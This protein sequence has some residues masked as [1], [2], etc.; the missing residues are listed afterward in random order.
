VGTGAGGWMGAWQC[1]VSCMTMSPCR[2]AP[3]ML[4]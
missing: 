3:G 2:A 1:G 4:S